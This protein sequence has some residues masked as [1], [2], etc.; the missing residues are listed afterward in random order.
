MPESPITLTTCLISTTKNA[1][2]KLSYKTLDPRVTIKIRPYKYDLDSGR[3]I[4]RMTVI[5][6]QGE[7]KS[8]CDDAVKKIGIKVRK[9]KV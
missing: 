6:C 9:N 8:Q 5:C 2:K 1:D 3:K 7:T 4:K